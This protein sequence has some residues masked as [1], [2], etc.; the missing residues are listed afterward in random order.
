MRLK[1]A[2]AVATGKLL[3][4]GPVDWALGHAAVN[5]RFAEADLAAIL[6]HHARSRSGPMLQAG[7]SRSLTQGTAGW[8]ALGQ[9]SDGPDD[10]EVAP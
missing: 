8:A 3:G 4:A 10:G 9:A 2:D 6:A 7:E 5:G 1:M